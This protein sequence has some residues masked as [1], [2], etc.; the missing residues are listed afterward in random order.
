MHQNE[1]KII[2][3]NLKKKSPTSIIAM[4]IIRKSHCNFVPVK[5]KS[6]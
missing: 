6:G 2:K 5:V 1:L 3:K 4:E